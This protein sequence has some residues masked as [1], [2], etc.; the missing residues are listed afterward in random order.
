VCVGDASIDDC[1]GTVLMKISLFRL[2]NLGVAA[3]MIAVVCFVASPTPDASS[4]PSAT[5]NV[6]T[7]PSPPGSWYTVAYSDSQWIALGQSPVVA[8]SS[9]GATWTESPVT[10]GSWHS[11][12]YGDGRFV[13]LSSVVASSEEIVS[14]NGSSWTALAG[15]TGTWSALTY[16]GGRFVAVSSAGAID[17]STNGTQWTQVWDH[18]NLDFTSVAYGGGHFVVTD[19]A[20]GAIGISTNGRQW[21]R[22]IPAP[23]SVHHWGSVVYGDGEFIALDGA[24]AGYYATSVYGYVWTLHQLSPGEGVESAAFGCGSFVAVGQSAALTEGLLSSRTGTTWSTTATPIDTTSTWTAVGYGAQRFVAVDTLGN[25]A[26]TRLSANCA[27]AIPTTPQQVSGNIHSGKVW[28]YMHPPSSAGGAPVNSYRV[29]ISEGSLIRH[30][31]APVYFEPNCIIAGLKNHQVYWI[32]AQAHNRF[33]YSVATDPEFAIPTATPG[34]AA[35]A[36]T[37]VVTAGDPVVVQVTGVR[38][39]DEGIYPI[40][41]ITVHVGAVSATCHPNPFGECLSSVANPPLGSDA[42]Y[43]TYTG[44]GVSYRSPTAHVTV[45]S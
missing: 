12:A 5:W 13:A 21:S 6:A 1:K 43:A 2:A 30:C 29:N 23:S 17:T 10:A 35:V 34:F 14:T 28:T 15:P 18:G 4:S 37:P 7:E 41:T 45:R 8:V 42:I 24:S 44:F 40:T 31:V 27:A 25:I 3:A 22:L 39:N 9:N 36:S 38:A 33:G 11:V 16:G 20:L 32:T 19:A 26:W